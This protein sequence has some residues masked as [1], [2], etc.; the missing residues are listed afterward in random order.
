MVASSSR[1]EAEVGRRKSS[2][3]WRQIGRNLGVVP[4]NVRDGAGD[5]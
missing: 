4:A 5:G 2:Y 3:R 1:Q